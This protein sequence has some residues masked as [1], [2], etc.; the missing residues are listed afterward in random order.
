MWY[1]IVK[2]AHGYHGYLNVCDTILNHIIRQN[3]SYGDL[4][5]KTAI[6]YSMC[7]HDEDSGKTVDLVEPRELMLL[8][9]YV[10][11]SPCMYYAPRPYMRM[12]NVAD[13]YVYIVPKRTDLHDVSIKTACLFCGKV[14]DMP[15]YI[16]NKKHI[17]V[18]DTVSPVYMSERTR[19]RLTTNCENENAFVLAYKT[20]ETYQKLR[21]SADLHHRHDSHCPLLWISNDDNITWPGKHTCLYVNETCVFKAALRALE[22]GVR[23][24]NEWLEF[25]MCVSRLSGY[26]GCSL[27]TVRRLFATLLERKMRVTKPT[28]MLM[29]EGLY[30]MFPSVERGQIYREPRSTVQ[31]MDTFQNTLADERA[32]ISDPDSTSGPTAE[33]ERSITSSVIIGAAREQQISCF[34]D[35][36]AKIYAEVSFTKSGIDPYTFRQNRPFLVGTT[37]NVSSECEYMIA[38]AKRIKYMHGFVIGHDS[39]AVCFYCAVVYEN[40]LAAW[41]ECVKHYDEL[42]MKRIIQ[43][44]LFSPAR[45]PTLG[46]ND[47]DY[48]AYNTYPVSVVDVLNGRSGNDVLNDIICNNATSNWMCQSNRTSPDEATRSTTSTNHCPSD[49]VLD[50]NDEKQRFCIWLCATLAF[51]HTSMCLYTTNRPLNVDE[52]FFCRTKTTNLEYYTCGHGGCSSCFND[53]SFMWCACEKGTR[54]NGIKKVHELIV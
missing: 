19:R 8:L 32:P 21:I 38:A 54:V 45:P 1:C 11:T 47:P 15:T 22:Y 43:Y 18:L 26:R 2:S 51:C 33:H 42:Q 9:N 23:T 30:Y 31:I 34:M 20:N 27:A 4:L 53:I 40:T 36:R 7:R 49:F 24:E 3:E 48:M 35:N 41:S 14:N 37:F 16:M 12:G 29:G 50:L 5:Q 6:V 46:A 10:D 52:C 44:A 13:D 25:T 28:G 17:N 39:A